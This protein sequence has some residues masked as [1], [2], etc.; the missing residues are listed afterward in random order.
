MED[1]GDFGQLLCDDWSLQDLDTYLDYLISQLPLDSGETTEL[2][3]KEPAIQSVG[4]YLG[5]WDCTWAG[6]TLTQEEISG[7]SNLSCLSSDTT[8]NSSNNFSRESGSRS[9]LYSSIDFGT[10]EDDLVVLGVGLK[11]LTSRFQEEEPNISELV[12]DNFTTALRPQG[13]LDRFNQSILNRSIST[14]TTT[15][16]VTSCSSLSSF[17][18]TSAGKQRGSQRAGATGSSA[19]YDEKV[20][21]CTYQGCNKVYSK[22]SH[23]KAHLRRH[24]GEKPFACQWPGC[25]WRFSRSDELARHKRSHSGIKPY[26]C[27][28]CEKRFSR[29]DHLAKHLKV[30]RR[31]KLIGLAT[32]GPPT[33]YRSSSIP[34]SVPLSSILQTTEI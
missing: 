9:E 30:H 2:R 10:C 31:A 7:F 29:S 34:V 3:V 26:R 18:Q 16:P 5:S 6:P 21:F 11:T 32:G 15:V 14:E 13:S 33:S 17:P 25:G 27:Q 8:S 1:F 20:F 22:S 19:K 23:L 28:I 24:T 12:S 4:G